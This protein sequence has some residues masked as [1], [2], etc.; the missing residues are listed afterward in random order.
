ML[1][2]ALL[3]WWR[4]LCASSSARTCNNQKSTGFWPC[5]KKKFGRHSRRCGIRSEGDETLTPTTI[6]ALTYTYDKGGNRITQL[7]QNAA[8][9]NLPTAVAAANIAYDA[10]NELTRW[11]SATTD[12][13]Y[14]NNGNLAPKCKVG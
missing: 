9:S 4:Q 14:D 12:L 8:A 2:C 11:N 5:A 1:M 6:E 13:T 7:R 10:A 3:R